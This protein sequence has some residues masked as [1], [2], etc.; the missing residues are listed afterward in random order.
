MPS[1]SSRGSIPIIAGR[2]AWYCLSS[3][4]EFELAQRVL[5]TWFMM[6]LLKPS[7]IEPPIR[8]SDPGSFSGGETRNVCG[9]AAD[10]LTC[11]GIIGPAQHGDFWRLVLALTLASFESSGLSRLA[12]CSR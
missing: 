5:I 2:T 6:M 8:F 1:I 12:T 3:V 10:D 7:L 4:S 11:F 9:G